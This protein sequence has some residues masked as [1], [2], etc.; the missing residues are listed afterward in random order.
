[1]QSHVYQSLIAGGL[2]TTWVGKRIGDDAPNPKC[3]QK[4]AGFIT[5]PALVTRFADDRGI[6]MPAQIRKERLCNECLEP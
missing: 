3:F 6:N 5:E 4:F 2:I 1:M